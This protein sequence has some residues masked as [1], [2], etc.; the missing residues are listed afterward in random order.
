MTRDN[1]SIPVELNVSV[2]EY[3]GR[4]AEMAII[5]DITE[6]KQAEDALRKSEENFHLSIDRLPVGIFIGTVDNLEELYANKAFL[7][8]QG[9]SSL[10][11]LKAI[12][13]QERV[14]TENLAILRENREQLKRGGIPSDTEITIKR[15]DGG[16]RH[17]LVSYMPIIWNGSPRLQI[18]NQD[19]TERKKAA[20]LLKESYRELQQTFE[21]V[22]KVVSATV[23]MRDPYTAGHQ[24]RVA[25]L[26]EQ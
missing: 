4:P 26:A 15:K 17:L 11:E 9:C 5:R 10:E 16:F 2:I 23:E 18:V 3:E 8:M 25:Q 14:V 22:I 21:G 20:Q 6:R 24:I 7:D 1:K 19:I 12:P 13:P